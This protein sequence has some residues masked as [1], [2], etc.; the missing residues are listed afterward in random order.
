[1]DGTPAGQ[2]EGLGRLVI[3]NWA[4][5]A[6]GLVR[7]LQEL[8]AK[9][10]TLLGSHRPE[11]V[12]AVL[13][14]A[15]AKGAVRYLAASVGDGL[16]AFAEQLGALEVARARSIIVLPQRGRGE[17][18]AFSR[19][20]CSAIHRACAGQPPRILVAVEDPE[21]THEFAGLGVST[22]FYPG[23][24]RAA[25]LAHG[26]L[27]LAVFRFMLALLHGGLRVQTLPVPAELR[28]KCFRDACLAIETDPE[29]RPVTVLGLCLTG[30]PG[31]LVNPGP[32][33]PLRAAAG[34]LVL[35]GQG[36]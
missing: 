1:M 28:D 22:I 9:S 14:A 25:L 10:L 33:Q 5:D 11:A 17:T 7:A 16:E 3:V 13:A 20:A 32:A 19:L 4:P 24:L 27:D 23:F 35:T 26:C 2:G 18:D 6:L 21:A 8:G 29:G 31:M 15:R 36:S 30:E 12:E 34:L